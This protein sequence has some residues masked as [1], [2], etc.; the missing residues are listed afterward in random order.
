MMQY[1]SL[2]LL[3]EKEEEECFFRVSS[4]SFKKRNIKIALHQQTIN[5]TSS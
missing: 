1:N 3:D 2:M 4:S 5:A